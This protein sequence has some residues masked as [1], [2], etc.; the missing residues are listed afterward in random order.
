MYA[1]KLARSTSLLL[2]ASKLTKLSEARMIGA[3][4]DTGG[5]EL[6]MICTSESG[7]VRF[8]LLNSAL[9]SVILMQFNGMSA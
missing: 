1:G 4:A 7:H 6:D 5:T 8:P 3:I 9:I 2:R